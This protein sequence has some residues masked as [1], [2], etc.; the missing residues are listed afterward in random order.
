[1]AETAEFVAESIGATGVAQTVGA[2]RVARGSQ[3]LHYL[4]VFSSADYTDHS[5]LQWQVTV[6]AADFPQGSAWWP[7]PTTQVTQTVLDA[8]TCVSNRVKSDL[9]AA[10]LARDADVNAVGQVNT[11]ATP[12]GL[13][14]LSKNASAYIDLGVASVT[15]VP[16]D[17]ARTST[18]TTLVLSGEA[19]ASSMVLLTL[20]QGSA[21]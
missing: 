3:Q 18:A 11:M 16:F 12:A 9:V 20:T 10:G 7:L 4:L 21:E 1:V 14:W 5:S 6:T 19:E 13:T 17:G 15:A 2:F 8:E